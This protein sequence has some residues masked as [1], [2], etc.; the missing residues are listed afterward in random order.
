[1]QNKYSWYT[2]ST[3]VNVVDDIHQTLAFGT[4]EDVKQLKKGIGVR[5]LTHYFI[6]HPKKVYS[7]P[8]FNFI[9][10]FLLPV[11]EQLE[12]NDYLKATPR[13]NR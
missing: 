10:K 4:L 9:S 13:N 6:K 2:T 11:H 8:S 3:Q 5:K 12:S 1:M 7:K